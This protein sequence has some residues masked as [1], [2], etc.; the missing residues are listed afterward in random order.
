MDTAKYSMSY[1]EEETEALIESALE[2]S[3]MMASSVKK[4]REKNDGD[5]EDEGEEVQF[6]Q[7]QSTKSKA[8]SFSASQIR[9][10]LTKK[11]KLEKL[12]TSIKSAINEENEE[13]GSEYSRAFTLIASALRQRVGNDDDISPALVSVKNV[14][15]IDD[16]QARDQMETKKTLAQNILKE[17][18]LFKSTEIAE[19]L[20]AD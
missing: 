5:E 19:D 2:D 7:R 18:Q 4:S 17:S 20:L 14:T 12:K 15:N 6:I 8:G 1:E 9:K 10:Q 16:T 3:K 13:G 11:K